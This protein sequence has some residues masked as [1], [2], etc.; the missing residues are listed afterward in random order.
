M[1]N[2]RTRSTRRIETMLLLGD[3]DERMLIRSD[4]AGGRGVLPTRR[5]PLRIGRRG[6]VSEGVVEAMS[7]SK[8]RGMMLLAILAS[9]VAAT[10]TLGRQLSGNGQV[11]GEKNDAAARARSDNNLK[12]I[13]LAIHSYHDT[14]RRLPIHAIYSKDGKTPLLSWRVAVLPYLEEGDLYN[15]FKLDEPWDSEHNKKLNAKMPK[16]YEMPGEKGEGLTYYQVI[17]G[18]DTV[19]LDK[20]PLGANNIPII[21][22]T[23]SVITQNNG[24]SNTIMAVEAKEPVIWT[25]PAD[26]SF[27]KEN[28]KVP[29]IGS[30]FA[31]DF[32]VLMCDGH[33]ATIPSDTTPARLRAKI[34]MLH[35][36]TAEK[37][38]NAPEKEKK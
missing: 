13:G 33:V 3:F 19:F 24:A 8:R 20:P 38:K 14:K 23:L 15:D 25:R 35:D 6:G 30:H 21:K 37:D 5:P 2:D 17:T 27:P 22:V 11:A 16:V 29:A 12:R 28:D 4:A 9:S 26:L 32:H 34:R 18:P 10:L 36:R 7:M 31:K 1:I